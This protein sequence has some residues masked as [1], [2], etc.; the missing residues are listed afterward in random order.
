MN[1][2]L[3]FSIAIL[4]AVSC[5]QEEKADLNS[6][7]A[8]REALR[9]RIAGIEDSIAVLDQQIEKLDTNKRY[10]LITT[11]PVEEKTFQHFFEV[12]GVIEA[13]KNVTLYPEMGG[14]VRSILVK[15][16]QK[17]NKGQVLIDFD[18]EL[19]RLQ[20]KEVETNLELA[21]TAYDRQ[22]RLWDKKIGSEMQYLQAKNQ[23]ETLE[24]SLSTLKAQLRKNQITAP[25]S[26]IIDEIWPKLGELTSPQTRAIRL[27]NLDKVYLKADVSEA[28][29]GKID[30]G[31]DVEVYFPAFDTTAIAK[32]A[33]IGNYINPNN[34]TFQIQVNL[35]NTQNHIK[36]NLMAYLR[37]KDFEQENAV[38]VPERLIQENPTGG[39]FLFVASDSKG[40]VKVSRIDV[41]V[42]QTYKSQTMVSQGLS[43][44]A[45]LV[46]KGAR[47][48]KDN[49]E[50]RIVNN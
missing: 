33:M 28:Y 48:I 10:T 34:R 12:Q 11:V 8:K 35:E 46:D 4:L 17:V 13:D 20:I 3:F 9:Q 36:P 19:I 24:A 43:A 23:K 37:V 44:N 7:K 5:K 27:V 41:E 38:V 21:Q 22:K 29:L 45:V 25:F 50:V 42:G 31:T 32:V 49:Q 16:G 1:R 14:V 18:T 47:S 2:I 30:V 26:G 6:L 15:E 39:K 40:V